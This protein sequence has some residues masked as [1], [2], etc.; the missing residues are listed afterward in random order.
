MV[1]L[2]YLYCIVHLLI[3]YFGALSLFLTKAE[4]RKGNG[5]IAFVCLV[6]GPFA[7]LYYL[8]LEIKKNW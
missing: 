6:F 8:L 7:A 1:L 4:D 3:A 5:R 2:V